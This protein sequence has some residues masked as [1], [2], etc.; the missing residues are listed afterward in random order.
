[1]ASDEGRGFAIRSGLF[2]AA[3]FVGVGVYL[4]FFPLWL[5]ERGL[6]GPEIAAILAA[7]LFARIPLMP[8]MTAAA[9]RLP[10]L[11]LAS[12]LYGFAAGLMLLLLIPAHG[13]WP[14]LLLWSGAYL[15]WNVLPALLDAIILAGVRQHGIDYARV[16][17]WASVG[18]VAASLAA[19]VV[20]NRT[21]ADVVFALLVATF[22]AGGAVALLLPHVASTTATAEPYGLRRAFA[23]PVLRWSLIAGGLVLGSNGA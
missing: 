3:I 12:A 9:E 13:F 15:L 8:F 17:L 18:F 6:S 19:A 22:L 23:D 14:I 11:G 10:S 20:A 21:S 16:R 4:P 7:P 1:M 5:A 2:G